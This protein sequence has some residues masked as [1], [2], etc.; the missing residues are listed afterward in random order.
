LLRSIR[1]WRAGD[2]RGDTF[3]G[4][5]LAAIAIPEQMA[6]ARLGDLSP[7]VG[8]LA[9]LSGCV[10]FAIF[11]T[12]RHMSVGADSTITPILAAG[13]A[14]LAASG[15][16][17]YAALAAVLA[18]MVG[19]T[20]ILA[21]LLRLGWI[22]D[23]LS[24]PV[25]AGF[26]AG[27]SIH[28]MVSQLPDL[29]G[30]PAGSGTVF[31]R[32]AAVYGSLG[33]VNPYSAVIGVAVFVTVTACERISARIPGA[34]I[35]LAAATLAVVAFHLPA[36]GVQVL[37]ML[38]A[39]T[40]GLHLPTVT[41]ED[42]RT[43]V[44]LTLLVAIVIM[45]QTA[46]TTRSFAGDGASGPGD[47]NRDFIG[48]GAGNLLSGLADAFPVN[49]SPPRTAIVAETGGRSQIA[50]LLAAAIVLALVLFGAGLLKNVPQ[51]ALA[52]ILFFVA[53]RILRWQT[54]AGTLRQA[55]TEFLLIAA[56]AFAIVALP[57]EI[58]VA[59]GIGL[60][61]LHG[62]WGITQA[63]AIEF[64]HVPGTSIWWPP[65]GEP[66]GQRV[67][68]V[69]VA[70]F[71]APLSFVNAG[72]FG[73]DFRAMV[74]ARA[75][76][77]KHVVFEASSVIDIEYTAAQTL[78]EVIAGCRGAG[79]S[80]SIARLESVRAQRALARF[81]IA[82]MLGPAGVFR[83][84]DD[85]VRALTGGSVPPPSANVPSSNGKE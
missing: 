24:V 48:V 13:L 27:I 15:S 43:L 59:I 72:R 52:G 45:V 19:A 66:A 79:V 78:R 84:V 85:A 2:L 25:T 39:A 34:L 18:L 3:A 40:P 64:E 60:S 69:L 11:G 29:L 8:F 20:V 46:A 10:A 50:G 14:L 73:Q 76:T 49:A 23:L 58:G 56:T 71:Q 67:E 33:D 5:T 80:F 32:I 28:I 47:I 77:V 35:G 12:S 82:A 21:G 44:P 61:L 22:A 41:F 53:V 63:R 37:G 36:R 26:L 42:V 30:L 51:A 74:A 4:L 6:T 9:F 83:S 1:G 70:A 7:Q 68:G 54:F 16:P 57:I 65:D 75:G 17:H 31:Q 81:G 62:I 55:P 38:P